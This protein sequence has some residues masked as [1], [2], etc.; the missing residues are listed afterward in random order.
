MDFVSGVVTKKRTFGA[1]SFLEIL[2]SSRK[3]TQAVLEGK[4]LCERLKGIK[5]N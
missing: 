4:D 3:I 1:L 5:R 2:T